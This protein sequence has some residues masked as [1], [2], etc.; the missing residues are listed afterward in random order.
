MNA[1]KNQFYHLG[2]RYESWVL[3]I[4]EDTFK[5]VKT[6]YTHTSYIS[7]SEGFEGQKTDY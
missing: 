7:Y 4:K 1:K 3:F 5:V 6:T 2:Y